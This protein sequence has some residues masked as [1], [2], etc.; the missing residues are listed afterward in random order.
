MDARADAC[1]CRGT[2]GIDA[3]VDQHKLDAIVAPTAGP[4]C[5]IDLV[6]GDH[7]HRRMLYAG[8]RRGLSAHHGSCRILFGT[9]GRPFVL[10]PRL[11]RAGS[12]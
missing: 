1:A 11:E 7:G 3:M 8:G 12:A 5:F 10:W 6:N 2:E 9:A 4:A